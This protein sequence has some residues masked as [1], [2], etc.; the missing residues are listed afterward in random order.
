MESPTSM[1]CICCFEGIHA[2]LRFFTWFLPLAIAASVCWHLN[3]NH[4]FLKCEQIVPWVQTT[5]TDAALADVNNQPVP[6]GQSP[7]TYIRTVNVSL[8]AVSASHA[9]FAGVLREIFVEANVTSNFKTSFLDEISEHMASGGVNNLTQLWL[10]QLKAEHPASSGTGGLLA[11]SNVTSSF[12]TFMF[13]HTDAQQSKLC[14]DAVKGIYACAGLLA[15]ILTAFAAV[16]GCE[17]FVCCFG[18][19][20]AWQARN[21]IQATNKSHLG[22]PIRVMEEE[23]PLMT[24]QQSSVPHG[25]AG[26]PPQQRQSGLACCTTLTSCGRR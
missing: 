22:V 14:N 6:L 8:L 1:G 24:K 12:F 19:C 5:V 10:T 7:D 3:S 23:R 2:W 16:A 4:D 15:L 21:T 26:P 25:S 20:E 11:V 17:V 18:S 13:E 9:T